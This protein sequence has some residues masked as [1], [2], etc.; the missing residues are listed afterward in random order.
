MIQIKIFLDPFRFPRTRHQVKKYIKSYVKYHFYKLESACLRVM[1]AITLLCSAFRLFASRDLA[2]ILARL[3]AKRLPKV[4][5]KLLVML[6]ARLSAS[7]HKT[8]SDS[9]WNSQ[10]DS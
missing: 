4:L 1:S 6:L 10:Q 8:L 9:G 5:A 3:L 7:R 2:I